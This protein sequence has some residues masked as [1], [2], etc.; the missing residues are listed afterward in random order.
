[1][2]SMGPWRRRGEE[3]AI[4]LMTALVTCFVFVPLAGIAVDLGVQRVARADMQAVAD[5]ASLDAARALG[6]GTTGSAELTEIAQ[7]SAAGE[8]G[9]VGSKPVVTAF[10][11][12]VDT[13]HAFVSD[14]FLGC[15]ASRGA[16]VD[17]GYFSTT[18]PHGK[19]ANAVLVTAASSVSHVI[20]GG[21]GG[22]CRSAIAGVISGACYD[23]GSY[24]AAVSTG[25]SALIN[26]LMRQLAQQSGKFSNGATVSA[27]DYAGLAQSQ[28]DLARMATDLNVASIKQLASSTVSLHD[29]YVAA[30]DAMVEPR[31]ATSVAALN[32][33]IGTTA[34]WSGSLDLSRVLNLSSGAAGLLDAT[35][36][37][38]D[39]VGGSLGLI[40]GSNVASVNIGSTILKGVANA[41]GQVKLIQGAHHFCG[42]PG[43]SATTA[44]DSSLTQQLGVTMTAQLN[45][46][47]AT[48]TLPGLDVAGLGTLA[49]AS[50]TVA[51][52]NNVTTS[53]SVAPTSTTLTQ[54]TCSGT[55]KGIGLDVTNGLATVTVHTNLSNVTVDT[56]LLKIAGTSVGIHLAVNT[57]VDV[58]VSV[59][60]S[61]VVSTSIT[62]PPQ[63]YDAAYPTSNSGV[64]IIAPTLSG[65]SVNA[66]VVTSL[67]GG[68]VS[69]GASISLTSAQV[70]Q[71]ATAVATS[72]LTPMF[73][74]TN[75][76]SFVS[77]VINPILGLLGANVGGA[78][79]MLSG[80]PIPT[81][82][83]P[84]LRG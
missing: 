8:T 5:S 6:N 62:V 45:P 70:S 73:D 26:P 3:G 30:L 56:T 83:A 79:V 35:M 63:Q 46:A 49:Q 27:I 38:L 15:G 17:N 40:N 64:G 77:T 65:T 10:P 54:V 9:T 75:P 19:S 50:S 24:A 44:T 33:L 37:A 66:N 74:N 59:S 22:V 13:A 2:R 47:S 81:C 29:F 20:M 51:L 7:D 55:A 53:V 21:S 11:G 4:A 57:A 78:D 14:Q 71:I 28:V 68:I 32:G 42:T 25:N 58:T 41:N 23:V 18:V 61:G 43:D 34:A 82:G 52:P 72:V 84:V 69:L 39:L 67:L 1:M 60:P 48:I 80:H 31:N 36:N 76:N 16:T 12:Y